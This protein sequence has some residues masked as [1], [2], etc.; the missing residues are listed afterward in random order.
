MAR[1]R[2]PGRPR[3]PVQRVPLSLRVMPMTKRRL[4]ALAGISG[5][6]IS[7]E[8]ELR[9]E[10]GFRAEED[11]W[12]PLEAAF[13]PRQAGLMM[14]IGS[15]MQEV[16]AAE[17]GGVPTGSGIDARRGWIDQRNAFENVREAVVRFLTSVMPREP[18]GLE[19]DLEVTEYIIETYL[20]VINGGKAPN[21]DFS[22]WAKQVHRLLGDELAKRLLENFRTGDENAR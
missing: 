21:E 22:R 4:D 6:S 14:I 5:R 16:S 17:I 8:A 12:R 1:K 19:L 2:K 10:E 3:D 20:T 13:G 7:Q 11:V 15:L 18:A 9:L